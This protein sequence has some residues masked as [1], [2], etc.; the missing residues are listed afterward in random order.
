MYKCAHL[1]FFPWIALCQDFPVE[2]ASVQ[3]AFCDPLLEIGGV[4]IDFACLHLTWVLWWQEV[5]RIDG[6]PDGFA[7]SARPTGNLADRDPFAIHFSDHK[8][9]LEC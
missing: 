1:T 5:R 7:I 6:L 3:H 8:S 9:F 4:R 2:L